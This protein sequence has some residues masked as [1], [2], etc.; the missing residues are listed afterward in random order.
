MSIKAFAA[1]AG[2]AEYGRGKTSTRKLPESCFSKRAEVTP[3]V[4]LAHAVTERPDKGG[5]DIYIYGPT[6]TRTRKSPSSRSIEGRT[7]FEE[8]P[9][10]KAVAHLWALISHANCTRDRRIQDDV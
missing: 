6:S 7:T 4:N 2:G 9:F 1:G 5:T 3:P 10:A 8:D